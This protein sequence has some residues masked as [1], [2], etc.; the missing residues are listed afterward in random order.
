MSQPTIA[1]P[2]TF[3]GG[4]GLLDAAVPTAIGS[5][6]SVAVTLRRVV[7]SPRSQGDAG[8]TA[9]LRSFEGPNV[10]LVSLG[11]GVQAEDYRLAG[12][13]A[14]RASG[15][16]AVAFLLPTE[17]LE[18]PA[19]IAQSL[20]EGALLASYDYKRTEPDGTFDVVPIGTPLPSVAV[21]DAVVAGVRRGALVAE[22]VNW[23]KFLVDS[24]AGYLP[25][26]AL[27]NEIDQRLNQ[28]EHVRVEVWTE[29]RIKE[30]RLGGLLGVGQGSAQP[31]RLVYATYDPAPD[32]EAAPRGA[33]GQGHHL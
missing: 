7:R 19:W 6:E 18:D 13:G 1:V 12:A 15:D 24:P 22:G 23:A 26:K 11:S 14:A 3:L 9:V 5:L 28:D 10:A 20:T 29:S 30:E 8:S 27:A 2:V 21:H 4:V 31:T 32:A 33:R 16:G 17:G 25:P